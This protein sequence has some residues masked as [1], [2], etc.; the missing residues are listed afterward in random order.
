[1]IIAIFLVDVMTPHR[2]ITLFHT[3]STDTWLK[4]KVILLLAFGWRS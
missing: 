1:M 2:Y 4:A 3:A